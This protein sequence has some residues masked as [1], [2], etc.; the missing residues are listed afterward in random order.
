MKSLFYIFNFYKFSRILFFHLKQLI[1]ML[2]N[3]IVISNE[4]RYTYNIG[5]MR[6]IVELTMP[7]YWI[8]VKSIP[9]VV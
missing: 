6:C 8:K 7:V 9:E 1:R 4:R 3:K 5:K 2:Y